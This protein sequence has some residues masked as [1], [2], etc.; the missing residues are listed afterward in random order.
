MVLPRPGARQALPR[1]GA[2]YGHRQ[3]QASSQLPDGLPSVR[4][5]VQAQ[6]GL[7]LHQHG[8]LADHFHALQR[9]DQQS[10]EIHT[11]VQGV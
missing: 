10:T 5:S 1:Q 4:Q 2:S 3:R 6:H 8:G 9:A 11:D 7:N